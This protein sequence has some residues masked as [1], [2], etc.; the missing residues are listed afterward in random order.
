MHI[1]SDSVGWPV[2]S[3]FFAVWD[4]IVPELQD[5]PTKKNLTF[6]LLSTC[7]KLVFILFIWNSVKNLFH[8]IDYFNSI[9][10]NNRQVFSMCKTWIVL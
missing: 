9:A 6:S 5:S 3:I 1:Y 7:G 2:R 8:W 10:L 4:C